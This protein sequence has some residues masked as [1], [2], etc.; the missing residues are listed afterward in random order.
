MEN[1]MDTL[2]KVISGD[3]PNQTEARTKKA[4]HQPNLI[5]YGDVRDLTLAPSPGLFESGRGY[6]FRTNCSDH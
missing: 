5:S 1:I 2:T 3:R 6:N 4:Y